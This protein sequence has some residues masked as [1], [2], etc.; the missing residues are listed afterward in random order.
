MPLSVPDLPGLPPELS[1]PVAVELAKPVRTIPAASA[2]P[3]GCL[4]EPKWDGYRLV[5]VRTG[6][7]TRV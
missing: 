5:V 7:S 4:Y 2:L 3:G 6:G 1:G